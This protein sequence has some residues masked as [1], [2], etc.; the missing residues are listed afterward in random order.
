MGPH[1][2]APRQTIGMIWAQSPTGVIG[3]DGTLPWHLPEDLARFKALTDGHPVIMGRRTWDS[4][5]AAA[6]PL[7]GRTNIVLSRTLTATDDAAADLR[8]AGAVVV[9]D[10]GAALAAAAEADGLDLVWVIGGVSL[11]EAALDVAT[12]AE[13][14]RVDT[15]VT[16]D[17]YAPGLDGRWRMT[18]ADPGP[19]EWA[20]SRTGLPYRFERWERER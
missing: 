6:R 16:G 17:T 5:P 2:T 7:P 1:D 15:E 14:T 8:A 4:L 13:I 20:H 18:A 19:G 3:V 12:R 9:Q 11:F 10:F